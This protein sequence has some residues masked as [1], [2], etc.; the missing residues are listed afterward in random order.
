MDRAISSVLLYPEA[1][2]AVARAARSNRLAG[3][4]FTATRA[5]LERLWRDVDRIAPTEALARRA[6]DLAELQGL[7]GYDA[8]HLASLEEMSVEDTVLLSAD[9]DLLRAAGSLGFATIDLSG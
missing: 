3:G 1:R 5:L 4:R 2:A 6:G 9:T 7:R 8:V